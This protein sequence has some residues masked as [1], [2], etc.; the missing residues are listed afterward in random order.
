WRV[1]AFDDKHSG[2]W[3]SVDSFKTAQTPAVSNPPGGGGGSF[4]TNSCH[5][6]VHNKAQLSQRIQDR[7]NPGPTVEGA[8]EFTNRIPWGVRGEG[9]GLL[10]KN[11]G[12]NIISWKGYSF[13]AGRICYPDGHIYKVLSDVPATNGA[14]WSDNDF[15]DKSLYVPA[16][17]PD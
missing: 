3:S 12:E 4:D 13:S 16:I 9:A 10:I 1:K 2:D 11:G 17:N 14:S 15:V 6:Y 7:V 8:S 5:Q